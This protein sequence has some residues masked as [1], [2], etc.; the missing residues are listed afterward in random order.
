MLEV[1]ILTQGTTYYNLL[2]FPV[3]IEGLKLIFEVQVGGTAASEKARLPRIPR[4]TP[5]VN[6]ER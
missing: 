4:W 3:K 6:K 1:T 2:G 5:N